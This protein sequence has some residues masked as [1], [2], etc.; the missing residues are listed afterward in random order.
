MAELKITLLKSLSGRKKSHIETAH[1]LGLHK[2]RDVSTQPDNP[3]TRGKIHEIS[4]LIEVS[5]G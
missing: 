3:Q 4:Y 1:S 2:I 5:E